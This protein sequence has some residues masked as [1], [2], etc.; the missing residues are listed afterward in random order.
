MSFVFVLYK[1][2]RLRWLGFLA[3]VTW[4]MVIILGTNQVHLQNGCVDEQVHYTLVPQKGLLRIFLQIT[5]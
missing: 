5:N 1:E 2:R 4:N 3:P